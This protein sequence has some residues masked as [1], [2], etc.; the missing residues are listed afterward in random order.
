VG[1]HA[2]CTAAE[3]AIDLIEL[4]AVSISL[5]A[6]RTSKAGARDLKS[7]IEALKKMLID[8]KKSPNMQAV[9][10]R[11]HGRIGISG[12]T[13]ETKETKRQLLE[14]TDTLKQLDT[15]ALD[16][17]L[18]N[19]DGDDI[20]LAP[21]KEAYYSH[22]AVVFGHQRSG[23]PAAGLTISDSTGHLT[24]TI[25]RSALPP[26]DNDDDHK[27]VVLVL[28]TDLSVASGMKII[29]DSKDLESGLA[30]WRERVREVLEGSPRL[31]QLKQL[32]PGKGK[33]SSPDGTARAMLLGA[34]HDAA[35]AAGL[36]HVD[37]MN[38]EY[39][40][41]DGVIDRLEEVQGHPDLDVSDQSNIV[42]TLE[43]L[44]FLYFRPEALAAAFLLD[45]EQTA[46]ETEDAEVNAYCCAECL[47]V[48]HRIGGLS[49][50]L[51]WP[52][53]W[54]IEENTPRRLDAAERGPRAPSR[55]TSGR[56]GSAGAN[57]RPSR[58]KDVNLELLFACADE[59]CD[60]YPMPAD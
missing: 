55:Q 29:S 30:A 7:G 21:K 25:S 28:H 33:D 24:F 23:L 59:Q 43:V 15:A 27:A 22:R 12:A 36:C 51:S 20:I 49:I 35:V 44:R 11:H 58:R 31:M 16:V 60:F 19:I 57:Q 45:P 42:R 56:A 32:L 37:S 41:T 48:Q 17:E 6:N 40:A 2:L 34:F 39:L 50:N 54:W 1:L 26:F 47:F 46:A 8:T 10:W 3:S 18:L 9:L 4:P 52:S 14:A 53:G 5:D 38:T 13:K